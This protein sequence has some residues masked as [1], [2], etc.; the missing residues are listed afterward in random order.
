MKNYILIGILV[1][2]CIVTMYTMR[3]S[4]TLAQPGQTII[5][6]PVV[7]G[8]SGVDSNVVLPVSLN[9]DKGLTF[10]YSCWVRIDNFAYQPGKQKVIFTKGPTDLSLM[11]PALLIDGN[12]NSLLLKVDTFGVTEVVAIPNIPA[13][14]WL[15]VVIVVDQNSMDI[16]V[17][18]ILHTH[19]SIT[20]L[21]R[22]NSGTVHTGVN[23]GFEGKL[24]GLTYY[25]Y[26]LKPTDIP[27][28]MGTKPQQEDIGALP[29]YFD[30]R[31]WVGPA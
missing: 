7:D 18:G 5:Q 27:A 30:I 4:F 19:H 6:G 26:F 21:P 24:A 31:W 16:Y 23:S 12:T 8:K 3:D 25:N 13:K 10:A 29:P 28:L 15:H 9:Q 1:L 2:A 14:K 22:Q 20:Q 11:C 17:N